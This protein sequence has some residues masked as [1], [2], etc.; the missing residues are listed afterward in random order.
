MEGPPNKEIDQRFLIRNVDMPS[1]GK[2]SHKNIELASCLDIPY[3]IG[4]GRIDDFNT[5][6]TYREHIGH[7]KMIGRDNKPD[8][9]QSPL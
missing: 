5:E 7:L 9:S 2:L 4:V 6:K 1:Q 8:K 3:Q